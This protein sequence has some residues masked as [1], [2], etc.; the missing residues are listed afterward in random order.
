M[1]RVKLAFVWMAVW[2]G[3]G[4]VLDMLIGTKQF[5]Y[6]LNPMRQAMW[7]LAHAH[8]VLLAVVFV[9]VARLHGFGGRPGP[10]RVMF[11][12]TL[13]VPLGFFLGGVAPT[14]T[15]PFI[16]V[17]LVPLGGFCYLRGLVATLAGRMQSGPA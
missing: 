6:L 7:R 8:G 16:G 15:D 12:G 4:L 10:E 14:E 9:V 1:N 5:F 17:W 11:L 13:L 2:V 3:F